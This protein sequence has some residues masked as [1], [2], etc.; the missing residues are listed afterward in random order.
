LGTST[1][2]VPGFCYSAPT[3]PRL[4]SLLL[5]VGSYELS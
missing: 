5:T 1:S 3:A 2:Q 4:S